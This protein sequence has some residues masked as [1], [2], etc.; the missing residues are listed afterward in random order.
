[1]AV[2]KSAQSGTKSP[3]SNVSFVP[4]DKPTMG[5]NTDI[6]LSMDVVWKQNTMIVRSRVNMLHRAAEAILLGTLTPELEARATTEAHTLRGEFAAFGYSEASTVAAS[7]ESLLK[8]Q[9]RRSQADAHELYQFV[10][11]LRREVEA[12]L[13]AA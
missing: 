3:Q 9:W 7:A 12:S 4:A 8:D 11:L 1:M 10:H 13:A 6:M 5:I 2:A